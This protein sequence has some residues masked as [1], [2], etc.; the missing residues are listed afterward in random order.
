MAGRLAGKTALITAA[1]Q[2][3]GRA[4]AELFIREGARVVATD[5]H[6][7]LLQGLPCRTERL[8]VTDRSAIFALIGALERLD[9]LVNVAGYVHHGTILECGEEDWD[10]SFDLN[11]RSM[12]WT[13]QAAIPKMLERRGG[14]I[15][16]LS[17]VASSLKGVPSRFVYSATKA[18]VIGMTKAVA[19][20]FVTQGIRCN[21]ICPGTI[22]S[23]SWRE[24]VA[25]Q[26]RRS[27]QSEET[28]RQAFIARQPMGRVGR[29]E[30]VAQ[31]ALYLA[32]DESAFTTG[33][34]YV[35]DGGWSM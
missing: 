3:I 11:A 8:D 5:L 13:M 1:G 32:S 4:T 16:N 21:A 31:L 29:P 30:E 15:V 26:A 24:R 14:A 12:F 18:A 10:F 17:S 35:I 34:V 25:E 28:V 2:G 22:D 20:D 9:V 33:A 19:A 7:G 23:P 6:P 27:G